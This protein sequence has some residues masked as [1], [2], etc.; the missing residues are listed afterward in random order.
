MEEKSFICVLQKH[1]N[2]R[3]HLPLTTLVAESRSV[4][5]RCS[6][7]VSKRSFGPSVS[8]RFKGWI[9]TR[10]AH[11]HCLFRLI[12]MAQI[13]TKEWLNQDHGALLT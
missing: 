5:V 11:H 6:S 9:A 8:Q 3:V 2:C 7:S 12:P 13:N 10:D 1:S 4:K